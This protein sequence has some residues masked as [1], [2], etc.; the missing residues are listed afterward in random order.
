MRRLRLGMMAGGISL[1]PD[2]VAFLTAA[3]ITDAT[4]TTAIDT[5][6]TDLKGY[7]IWN[8]IF[9]I[10]P[11]VGGTATTHKFN[12]KNP[13]DTNAAFR[14]S[15]VGGWTHSANGAKPNGTNAYAD[16]F[17]NCF[18]NLTTG[19]THIS[20][21]STTNSLTTNNFCDVGASNDYNISLNSF[22]LAL[23]RNLSGTPSV[24]DSVRFSLSRVSA[25]VSTSDG[26]YIGSNENTSSRKLYKNGILLGQNLNFDNNSQPTHTVYI[27][28]VNNNG[29]PGFYTDRNSALL[30]I[31]TALTTTEAANFYTAVQAFQTT[32][33]RQV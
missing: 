27:G 2:A 31:G 33:G 19:N 8:K 23:Q 20:Y 17:L 10:Y 22:Q 13:A 24:F 4:I 5:L 30:S 15:F 28:A 9:A 3:G 6:V 16:T 32:L 7:G 1:D 25:T 11:F 29:T 21:Y 12:L 14:L 18:N 26:F